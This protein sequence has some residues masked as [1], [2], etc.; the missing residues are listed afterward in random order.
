[1]S[2]KSRFMLANETARMAR[3]L[4]GISPADRQFVAETITH[5]GAEV[6][7]FEE[8]EVSKDAGLLSLR[9]ERM[10]EEDRNVV[11]GVVS[12]LLAKNKPRRS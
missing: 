1:M 7:D 10:S 2:T 11:K 4:D 8:V 12:R 3:A 9:I 6:L 5:F